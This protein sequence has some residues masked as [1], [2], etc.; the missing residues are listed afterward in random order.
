MALETEKEVDVE[1]IPP[2]I[3]EPKKDGRGWPKGKP[4]KPRVEGEAK[5]SSKEK[6]VK[7]EKPKARMPVPPVF[8]RMLADLPYAM[9]PIISARTGLQIDLPM[10]DQVSIVPT[11]ATVIETYKAGREA[12]DEWMASFGGLKIHPAVAY[13]GS[14]LATIGT[15]GFISFT[16]MKEAQMQVELQKMRMAQEGIDRANQSLGYNPNGTVSSPSTS[17]P[18]VSNGV[19]HLEVTEDAAEPPPAQ[20]V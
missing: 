14:V 18:S 9:V 20:E 10:V 6:A 4:R 5:A 11:E 13:F 19:L 15:A 2:V 8:N 3:P 12:F 1:A 17:G 16:K 7:E